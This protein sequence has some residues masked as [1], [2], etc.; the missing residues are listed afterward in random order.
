MVARIA[1]RVGGQP[2]FAAI[3]RAFVPLDRMLGQLTSG[4]FVALGIRDLPSLLLTT[5]GRVSGKARVTPLLYVADGGGFVVI[6]SNWGRPEHPAWSG[7][8]LAQPLATVTLGGE[9][10]PI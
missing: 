6:G 1:L 8:L 7:N 4:R 10:I 9:H 2:W 5:T 3:G